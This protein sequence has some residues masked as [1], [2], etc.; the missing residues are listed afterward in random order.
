MKAEAWIQLVVRWGTDLQSK[1]AVRA[2][3][4]LSEKHLDLDLI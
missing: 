4:L 2:C 1:M 3:W